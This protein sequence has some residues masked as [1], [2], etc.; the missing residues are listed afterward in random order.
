MDKYEL[1]GFLLQDLRDNHGP[2]EEDLDP[3]ILRETTK[4]LGLMV[5]HGHLSR[6]MFDTTGIGNA[7]DTFGVPK[8]YRTYQ[9]TN[10]PITFVVFADDFAHWLVGTDA[11]KR[12]ELVDLIKMIKE[13]SWQRIKI[14]PK[15]HGSLVIVRSEK[16]STL[17]FNERVL[18]ENWH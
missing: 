18:L 16:H 8:R 11:R 14:V 6:D 5:Q 9:T 15:P 7:K 17:K 12:L 2:D 1:L 10:Y 3:A 13:C 4:I